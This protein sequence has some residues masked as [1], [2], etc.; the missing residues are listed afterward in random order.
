MAVSTFGAP[1][2]KNVESMTPEKIAKIL[3]VMKALLK[4]VETDDPTPEDMNT[5]FVLARDLQKL[6]PKSSNQFGVE[7]NFKELGLPETGNIIEIID[8][9]ALIM[10]RFGK[11]P[12]LAVFCLSYKQTLTILSIM[13]KYFSRFLKLFPAPFWS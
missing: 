13:G 11:C 10:T 3:P 9:E 6:V 7:V 5:L 4:V 8:G 12:T 1:Q 2:F